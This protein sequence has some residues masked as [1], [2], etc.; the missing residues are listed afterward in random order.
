MSDIR[1]IVMPKWGLAMEEGRIIGWQV[2][3]GAE[4]RL[5]QD[6]VEIETSKITNTLGATEAGVL[7]RRVGELDEVYPCGALIAV[8]AD[9][10][11]SDA[12]IDAFVESFVVV[13]PEASDEEMGP[14]TET[15]EAGGRTLRYLD[16]G[17]GAETVLFLHGFGGDLMNWMF[18]QPEVSGKARTIALDLPGHGAS[19]K[20]LGSATSIE[21]LA[22]AVGEFA[23]AIGLE[24]AHVVG[25][26]MGGGVAVALAKAAPDLVASLTLLAPAG[27]GAPVNAQFLSDFISAKRRRAMTPVAQMLFADPSVV[28]NEMVEEMIRFKRLDGVEAVLTTL[29]EALSDPGAPEAPEGVPISVLWGT[30]D[31]VVPAPADLPAPFKLD[32]LEKV[33][34]MP[35]MEAASTVVETITA[36]LG[37]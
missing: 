14:A 28:S 2:E 11:V 9:A 24:R 32:R 33:G 36:H 29:S 16:Q 22:A 8:V 34:H 3:E 23:K 19:S 18:V 35:H 4:I 13:E 26:S 20:E 7:R 25:H 10:S 27:L 5:G 15:V 12:D 17:E 31:Q 1:P 37:A 30:E 6:L 21:G